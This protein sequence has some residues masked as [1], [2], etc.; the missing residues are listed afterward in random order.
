M[1]NK[2]KNKWLL[3]SSV[4]TGV[5]TAGIAH[6][7]TLF[8]LPDASTTLNS[9]GAYSAPTFTA[10]LPV[11]YIVLGFMIGALV[12]KVVIRA[13]SGGAKRVLGGGR[14]GGRRRR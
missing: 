4:V 9:T 2:I 10:F 1:I 14:R 7:Q 3:I 5:L 13:V 8:T 12:V 11:A 6:G